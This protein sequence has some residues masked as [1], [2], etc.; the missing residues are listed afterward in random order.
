M[1]VA[2]KGA[3]A[4]RDFLFEPKYSQDLGTKGGVFAHIVDSSMAFI[5]VHNATDAS[6]RIPHKA[7]LGSIAEFDQEGAYIVT[8]AHVP[9]ATDNTS[10]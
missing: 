1:P 4:E 9:L 10:T 5:Q 7:R 3:L 2:Y 8:E 6:V